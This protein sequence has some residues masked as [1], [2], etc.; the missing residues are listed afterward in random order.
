MAPV[1][2]PLNTP[3]VIKTKVQFN[4]SIF[5]T[6]R[7]LFHSLLIVYSRTCDAA[8]A[9]IGPTDLFAELITTAIIISCKITSM[10]L[11]IPSPSHSLSFALIKLM[12]ATQMSVEYEKWPKQ[13]YID[14]TILSSLL[15]HEGQATYAVQCWGLQR[16]PM[17]VPGTTYTSHKGNSENT[18]ELNTN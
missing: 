5:F 6:W 7:K 11:S 9:R 1:R 3:L 18:L 17:R 4:T 16:G 12:N 2:P 13:T 15:F 10:A 14:H 8:I